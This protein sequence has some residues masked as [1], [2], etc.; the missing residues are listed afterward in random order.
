MLK[1]CSC[2]EVKTDQW[3]CCN[4]RKRGWRLAGGKPCSQRCS[5]SFFQSSRSRRWGGWEFAVRLDGPACIGV[6]SSASRSTGR[7]LWSD[8]SAPPPPS[9]SLSPAVTPV[10]KQHDLHGLHQHWCCSLSFITTWDHLALLVVPWYDLVTKGDAIQTSTKMSS[11]NV[12][13]TGLSSV[14]CRFVS[15]FSHLVF[16]RSLIKWFWQF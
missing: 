13:L 8:G 4:G 15:S 1:V 9:R 3:W 10:V 14:S 6:G 16:K 5:W 11:T 12:S 7:W 2:C